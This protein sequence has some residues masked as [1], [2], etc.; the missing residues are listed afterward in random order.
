MA[1]VKIRHGLAYYLVPVAGREDLAQRTAFRGQVITVSDEEAARLR[2]SGAAVD[3]DEELPLLGKITPI[4]N[5]ASD[6]ELFAWVSV[7]TKAE[8]ARAIEERP[9]LGD[10]LLAAKAAYDKRIEQQNKFLSGI[11]ETVAEG[12]KAAKAAAKRKQGNAKSSAP[13]SGANGPN[14]TGTAPNEEDLDELEE[15]DEEEEELDEDDPREVVK[16][17][18]NSISKFLTEHPEQIQA[19]LD[20]EANLAQSQNREVRKGVID[21]ASVAANT[22][23][24]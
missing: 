24:Q 10:R 11:E 13:T 20:A 8:I 3:H 6:E 4:P 21:A 5:T 2:A 12:K 7:A 1:K 16:G 18:V 19:V 23:N 14:S 17:D 22:K 9:Q 15:L